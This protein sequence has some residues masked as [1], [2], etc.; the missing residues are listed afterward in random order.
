MTG[1]R[2]LARVTSIKA[3]WS[4]V[5]VTAVAITALMSQIGVQLGWPVWLRPMVAAA[6]ALTMVQFLAKGMTYPL[7]QMA[8]ASG[9]MRNRR[10]IEPIEVTGNDEIGQLAHAFNSMARDLTEADRHQREFIANASHELRTPVAA[11]RSTLENLVDGVGTP[12]HRTLASMLAQAEHLG[13]LVTQLLDLSRLDTPGGSS[14]RE[15]VDAGDLLH[16]VA[17]RFALHHPEVPVE[18]RSALG[19]RLDADPVRIE[20]LF[21]NLVSNAV[22]FTPPGEFVSVVAAANTAPNG[23]PTVRV[24]V[25]DFGPGIPDDLK[26]QVFRRFWQAEPS[27]SLGG[28]GHGVTSTGGAGLGLSIVKRIV[29][30]HDGSIEILDRAPTG[31]VMVVEFPRQESATEA[32]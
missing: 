22:R 20:Q 16:R 3:K 19:L 30:T 26:D 5:I 7:R 14:S 25:S 8:A 21:T 2:P 23:N 15:T 31:T 24:A 1:P 6:L 10:P 18:V 9:T 4:I 32:E 11:L 12:D 29:E 13:D 28:S 17:D 27:R